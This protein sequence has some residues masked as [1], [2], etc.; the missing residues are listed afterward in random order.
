MY[1][2][3]AS[4]RTHPG[5]PTVVHSWHIPTVVHTQG[6]IYTAVI[7]TPREAILGIYTTVTHLRGKRLSGASLTVIPGQ[8]A[9]G[10]LF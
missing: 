8:E 10:S 5:I 3:H 7:H 6:G 2:Q 9:L 4:L 1:T